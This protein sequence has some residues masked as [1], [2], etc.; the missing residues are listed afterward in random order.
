MEL[1]DSIKATLTDL[2]SLNIGYIGVM[3]CEK[4]ASHR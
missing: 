1:L 3:F 2:S 4:E